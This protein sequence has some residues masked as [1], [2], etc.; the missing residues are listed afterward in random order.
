[1][2]KINLLGGPDPEFAKADS[3]KKPKSA[4]AKSS[5]SGATSQRPMQGE[6][7][8]KLLGHE[9][10]TYYL[11]IGKESAGKVEELANITG[12]PPETIIK[13]V[14][15]NLPELIRKHITEELAGKIPDG[16]TYE[17]GHILRGTVK[18][19]KSLMSELREKIDPFGLGLEK[20]RLKLLIALAFE[21]ALRDFANDIKRKA[22]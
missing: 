2:A 21:E 14:R 1:M 18:I 20:E 3:L 19:A 13:A 9:N 6:A 22:K 17:T 11:K 8:R 12:A 4:P 10:I 5:N 7:K 15:K 16:E